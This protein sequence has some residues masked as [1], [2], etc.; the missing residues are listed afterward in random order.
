MPYPTPLG[1]RLAFA[2]KDAATPIEPGTNEVVATVTVAYLI[3]P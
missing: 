2:A 3:E 1:E